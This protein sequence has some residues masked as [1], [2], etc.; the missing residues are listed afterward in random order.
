MHMKHK[1]F[2]ILL[3]LS[4]II[5]LLSAQT[6]THPKVEKIANGFQFVEGPVWMEGEG[7]LF[8]DIPANR[9]YLW[10][11][12]SGV[13]VYQEPSG[14]SNGLAFD[15]EGFLLLAQHGPRQVGRLETIGIIVAIATHYNGK[16][17]NSP[18]DLA[19][20][21]DGSIFFTD[22]PYGLTEQSETGFN[23]IYR[24]NKKGEVQLL[25][26]TLYRPNGIAFSPDETRLYVTDTESRKVYV[27]DVTDDTTITSKKELA[28]LEPEGSGTDGM[29][30]DPEGFLYVSG[31]IGIW[32]LAPDGIPVDTIP[33]PGQTTNCAW[34]GE[35]M[36]SLFVTSGNAVYKISNDK[37]KVTGK[38]E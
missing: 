1:Y 13:S 32:I 5:N 30:V 2:I 23:G 27:W 19:V 34:G 33:V 12:G 36:Q 24:L 28:F 17:L 9:V 21:S 3:G 31:P 6:L 25:D 35:N 15:H 26:S 11:E 29:K 37:S 14:N 10:K 38:N 8:S 18:N 4:H 16:R 20:H 7:L 22:P